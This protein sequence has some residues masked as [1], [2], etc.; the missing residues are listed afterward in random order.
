[1]AEVM[2]NYVANTDCASG[3]EGSP[4]DYGSVGDKRRI[5]KL[6]FDGER[7]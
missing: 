3:A 2:R 7:M 6:L 1:M 4:L 5:V